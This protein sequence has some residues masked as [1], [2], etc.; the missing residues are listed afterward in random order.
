MHRNA[1]RH[2][3]PVV[4]DL[5]R[6]RRHGLVTR[7]TPLQAER[8]RQNDLVMASVSGR[9]SINVQVARALRPKTTPGGTDI[10]WDRVHRARGLILSGAIDDMVPIAVT[11]DALT[12]VLRSGFDLAPANAQCVHCGQYLQNRGTGRLV[13][14]RNCDNPCFTA[15]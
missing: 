11:A 13:C 5:L 9:P 15:G 7:L 6:A 14:P 2:P 3:D 10:R 4:A 12:T 8:G 1:G